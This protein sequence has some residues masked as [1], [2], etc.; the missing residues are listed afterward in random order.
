MSD[1]AAAHQL[2]Q[3]NIILEE[4][5]TQDIF[6][7]PCG[8]YDENTCVLHREV[9]L[10]EMSGDEEDLLANFQ[11]PFAKRINGVFGSCI[12]RI[13][14]I[15]APKVPKIIP[16]LPVGDRSFLLFA[17]RRRS[18]G[19]KFPMRERCPSCNAT[20]IYIYDLSLIQ[21]LPMPEPERRHYVVELPSG[22][23]ATWHPITGA[24]DLRK[25]EYKQALQPRSLNIFIR[26]DDI[27]G[28][29]PTPKAVKR[30]SYRDRDFLRG[31][32]TKFEG[33]VETSVEVNC[34]SCGFEFER[35]IDPGS[36][37]FFSPSEML[38]YEK[39][40]RAI[41]ATL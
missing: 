14:D 40:K 1:S 22:G 36:Q 35:D 10:R 9:H 30:M 33:G 41:S 2:T 5:S 19:D 29:P 24:D 32:F 23:A 34:K 12:T 20:H 7:L 3:E 15:P 8:Y 13:G 26:L 11:I 31:Q 39:R 18:L 27:N 6:T 16:H 25:E 21:A 37:G 4:R 17:L 28:E 38:E